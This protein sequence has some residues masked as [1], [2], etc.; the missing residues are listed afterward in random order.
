M[1]INNPGVADG[2]ITTAKLADNA[3]T[4]AKVTDANITAG[5]LATLA[6]GLGVSQTMT[7]VTGSRAVDTTYQNTTGRPITIFI[8]TQVPVGSN[9]ELRSDA[10]TPPTVVIGA[11]GAP[12]TASLNEH[13]TY[14]VPVDHYYRLVQT[15]AGTFAKW[16]EL[17]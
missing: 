10:A 1:Q 11:H 2:S 6:L 8:L 3:V 9:I 13:I 5:K 12:T 7:D 17:R 16:H 14:I 4:T 15:T